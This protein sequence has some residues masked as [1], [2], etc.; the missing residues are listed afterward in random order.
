MK[1]C[2]TWKQKL[3]T[4]IGSLDGVKSYVSENTLP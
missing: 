2:Q 4:V 3:M 1:P